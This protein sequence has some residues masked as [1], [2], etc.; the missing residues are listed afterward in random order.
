MNRTSID[1]NQNVTLDVLDLSL[2]IL[3][4]YEGED[5]SKFMLAICTTAAHDGRVTLAEAELIRVVA[6]T[7]DCPVPPILVDRS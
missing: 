2:D 4:G 6:A 5:L 7:L 1:V 3:L